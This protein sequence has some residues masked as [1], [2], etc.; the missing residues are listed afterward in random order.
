VAF[1]V[2]GLG[3]LNQGD[4]DALRDGGVKINANFA[5]AVEG[6]ASATN[7]AVAVFDGT[8]GKAVKPGVGAVIDNSGN[9]GL[10]QA[11]PLNL[12]SVDGTIGVGAGAVASGFTLGEFTLEIRR[13]REPAIGQTV[14][15]GL[16]VYYTGVNT[17]NTNA[18]T[19]LSLITLLNSTG[20]YAATVTNIVGTASITT[21]GATL[22]DIDITFSVNAGNLGTVFVVAHGGSQVGI[23]VV[24]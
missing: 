8:S 5:K 11:S 15:A 1:D 2:I 24:A 16:L 9:V 6:P 18:T 7:N 13:L 22:R 19:F 21:S 10:N 12:L 23:N 17:N 20:T 3:T 4:G 14:Q